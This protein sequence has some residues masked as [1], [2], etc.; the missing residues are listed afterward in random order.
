MSNLS[1]SCHSTPLFSHNPA[2]DTI[3]ER[4]ST[5]EYDCDDER[6]TT[7]G[8]TNANSNYVSRA[9]P[10]LCSKP[11]YS[12]EVQERYV[13]NE[14]E[15]HDIA[16][17]NG[18]SNKYNQNVSVLVG[19]GD[20][21]FTEVDGSKHDIMN[22]ST[23]VPCFLTEVKDFKTSFAQMKQQ[24]A[25]YVKDDKVKKMGS[26]RKSNAQNKYNNQKTTIVRI[27]K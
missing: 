22:D 2:Y 12:K 8:L 18:F 20:L 9:N 6:S 13:N 26:G 14:C 4:V 7:P 16:I 15:V 23:T 25:Q 3:S 21:E 27:S 24:I 17:I 19:Y 5:V 10:F 11:I 1:D